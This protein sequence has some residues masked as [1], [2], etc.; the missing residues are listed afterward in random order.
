[1]N[2]GTMM[3]T[4][5]PD[6]SKFVPPPKVI[7][8]SPMAKRLQMLRVSI[9]AL[10]TLFGAMDGEHPI[11]VDGMPKAWTVV[12]WQAT[13]NPAEIGVFIE[14]D[15]YE[16]C[17]PDKI[18]IFTLNATMITPTEDVGPTSVTEE[19]GIKI[20]PVRRKPSRSE[21]RRA[22]RTQ[23]KIGPYETSARPIIRSIPS[24]Q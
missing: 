10:I 1:M 8:L 7:N 9:P 24:R 6:L 23:P 2:E 4:D 3:R 12:G 15:E 19:D 20:V 22:M 18:P 5:V 17:D 21:R 14:S 13:D 11:R 16:P